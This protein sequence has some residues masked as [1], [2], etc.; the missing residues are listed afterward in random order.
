[1]KLH[2]KFNGVKTFAIVKNSESKSEALSRSIKRLTGVNY[3]FASLLSWSEQY[4]KI[5]QVTY[6]VTTAGK[7]NKRSNSRPIHNQ[8]SITVNL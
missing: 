7:L 2:Y 6:A 8:Y 3:C 4:G 1:M 5:N